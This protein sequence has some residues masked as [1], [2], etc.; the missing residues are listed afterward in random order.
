MRKDLAGNCY[1][2]FSSKVYLVVDSPETEQSKE[3]G[4]QGK[5]KLLVCKYEKN[6]SYLPSLKG[7]LKDRVSNTDKRNMKVK[8]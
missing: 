1:G 6:I 7:K 8:F 2:W 5:K 4:L 3:T